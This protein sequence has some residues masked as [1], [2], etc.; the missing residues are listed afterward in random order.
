MEKAGKSLFQSEKFS[1]CLYN[2][3]NEREKIFCDKLF[4]WLNH[5]QRQVY[6]SLDSFILLQYLY[7][8][9]HI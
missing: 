4:G 3:L 2:Y 8:Q 7:R 5:N 9:I 1:L 6:L